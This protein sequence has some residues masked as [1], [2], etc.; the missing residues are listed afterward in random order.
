MKT[1]PSNPT[2]TVVQYEMS[3]RNFRVS[4]FTIFAWDPFSLY[5]LSCAP[6]VS[7]IILFVLIL[8]LY[9]LII[10]VDI[11]SWVD[12]V[13]Y[14]PECLDTLYIKLFLSFKNI[15]LFTTIFFEFIHV[16]SFTQEYVQDTKT[17]NKHSDED[18]KRN[19]YETSVHNW[20]HA[21]IQKRL[22]LLNY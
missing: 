10:L 16:I 3:H 17:E 13:Y 1:F 18:G 19:C 9:S 20:R 15:K 21:Q 14:V 11:F 7:L 22:N 6:Y 12:V 2:G 5:R 4:I 8:R